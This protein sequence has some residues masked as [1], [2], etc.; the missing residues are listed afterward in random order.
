MQV[1]SYYGNLD[2]KSIVTVLDN[3]LSWLKD[4]VKTNEKGA[5]RLWTEFNELEK[6]LYGEGSQLLS[7]TNKV[8]FE[9]R[10]NTIRKMLDKLT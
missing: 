8:R 1:L 4:E 3:G 5:D 10:L 7:M 9:K 6:I 2:K